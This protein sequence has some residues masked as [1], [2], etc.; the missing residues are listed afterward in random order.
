MKYLVDDD[1]KIDEIGKIR[2]KNSNL[3][4]NLNKCLDS[5]K[6]QI[7]L[8]LK[9]L[10]SKL[11]KICQ[12]LSILKKQLYNETRKLAYCEEIHYFE[13]YLL[14]IENTSE[15]NF[16]MHIELAKLEYKYFYEENLSFPPHYKDK[17]LDLTDDYEARL[18]LIRNN[19]EK[20]IDHIKDLIYLKQE[21][22]IDLF[23]FYNILGDLH[24]QIFLIIKEHSDIESEIA[25]TNLENSLVCYKIAKDC[26]EKS[27]LTDR[28]E[29]RYLRIQYLP[30]FEPFFEKIKGFNFLDVKSK[31]NVIEHLK[32]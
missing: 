5:E 17:M 11:K 1:E 25:K 7:Y 14:S 27:P 10:N 28:K 3:E 18:N 16:L 12:N 4:E 29:K 22:Q 13:R 26:Y 32:K 15:D 8:E 19:L 30:L 20:G 23:E 6:S 31:I 9:N 2:K 24:L 21:S